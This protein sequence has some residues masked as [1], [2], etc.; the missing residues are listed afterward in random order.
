MVLVVVMV[1]VAVMV[2]LMVLVVVAVVVGTTRDGEDATEPLGV[3]FRRALD[4]GDV[5]VTLVVTPTRTL[6]ECEALALGGAAA[7]AAIDAVE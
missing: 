5:G 2:V 1:L 3:T 6:L 7:L 4:G